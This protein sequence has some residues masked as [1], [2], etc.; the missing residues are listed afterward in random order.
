M[1][2]RRPV[3]AAGASTARSVVA[4]DAGEQLRRRGALDDPV[5]DPREAIGVGNAGEGGGQSLGSDGIELPR[6]QTAEQRPFFVAALLDALGA[7]L[8]DALGAAL[9]DAWVGAA[10]LDARGARPCSMPCSS[11]S[12]VHSRTFSFSIVCVSCNAVSGSPSPAGSGPATR[13]PSWSHV[14]N[15]CVKCSSP[16]ARRRSLSACSA[17]RRRAASRVF[18]RADE[19]RHQTAWSRLIDVLA[20]D[21][22]APN[23]NAAALKGGPGFRLRVGDWRVLYVVESPEK[24]L[25]VAAILSRGEA[26][27]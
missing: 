24:L 1:P 26:Y 18:S 25:R 19:R 27:R 13:S 2:R 3:R 7:A 22:T 4:A 21:P 8:F 9:F 17:S 23:P 5:A 6:R 20:A 14:T 11:H 15:A 12:W 10:L 16:C